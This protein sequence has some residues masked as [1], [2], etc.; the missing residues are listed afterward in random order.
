MTEHDSSQ[1]PQ[2]PYL[3]SG[4]YQHQQLTALVPEHIGA[5]VF[6]TGAIILTTPNE[7]VLDFLIRM[8]RPH[9]VVARVVL[10]PGVVTSVVSALRLSRQRWEKRFGKIPAIEQP[11][12]PD[13]QPDLDEVYGELKLPEAIMNGTYANGVMISFSGSEFAFDFITN[14][15]PRSA[16]S[17]RVYMSVPQ[18]P[19][20]IDALSQTLVNYRK[21]FPQPG[22]S[23]EQAK[24]ADP[25]LGLDT[26]PDSSADAS[27]DLSSDSSSSDSNSPSD[28]TH[29]DPPLENPPADSP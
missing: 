21:S 22:T 1:N 13:R 27:H 25:S 5:G 23:T 10:P 20:F 24:S 15:F 26:P 8:A 9:Q 12:P 14:F 18:V 2:D 11:P 7:F 19:R 6:C 3:V 17:Q 4:K 29:E 28:P 16:V